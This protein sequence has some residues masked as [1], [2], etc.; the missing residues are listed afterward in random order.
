MDS[1]YHYSLTDNTGQ[2]RADLTGALSLE[3]TWQ[4]QGID[5]GVFELPVFDPEVS[6]L[7][8]DDIQPYLLVYRDNADGTREIVLNGPVWHDEINGNIVKAMACSGDIILGKRF[9]AAQYSPTDLGALLKNFVDTTNS[10][11]GDTG[12]ETNS[13]NITATSSIDVDLRSSPPT[14]ASMQE[15]FS[16]QL[17]GCL[18]WVVAKEFASGKFCDFY[19]GPRRGT[20]QSDDVTFS[21]GDEV[22]S[23]CSD[24][25]RVRDKAKM[26]NVANGYS[27]TL[28]SQ[29]TDSASITAFRQLIEYVSFTAED[30]QDAI[31]A[32]TQGLIDSA[33]QLVRL[34]E[35]SCV[36][37]LDAPRLFDDVDMGSDVTL[38]Y[39]QGFV[40]FEAVKR[41][42]SYSVSVD[43]STGVE[44]PTEARFR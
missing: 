29:R 1:I 14:I 44:I 26:V 37:N 41:I 38:Y 8:Q 23:N 36:P 4:E 18:S 43:M 2:L 28:T 22:E 16:S 25:G 42:T 9:T 5:V 10:T 12:I 3:L 33:S 34:A 17:D 19:A 7:M 30:S 11:D 39:R 40:E 21:Y 13:A 35:Y 31:N 6:F 24:M 32:R 27:D 20:D 15:Q